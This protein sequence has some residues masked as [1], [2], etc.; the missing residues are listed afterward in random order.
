M[1]FFLHY[2]NIFQFSR[3]LSWQT[4]KNLSIW[5]TGILL[6]ANFF[7]LAEIGEKHFP[8]FSFLKSFY[9]FLFQV[10]WFFLALFAVTSTSSLFGKALVMAIGLDLLLT[11]WQSQLKNNSF[12]WLFWQIKREISLKEQKIFLYLM[13]GLFSLLTLFLI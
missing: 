11:E 7:K 4:V 8:E 13:T 5:L 1:L 12:S 9:S 3:F 2:L 6:G 10:A